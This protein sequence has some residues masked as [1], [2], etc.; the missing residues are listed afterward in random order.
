MLVADSLRCLASGFAF[1]EGPVWLPC[2]SPLLPLTGFEQGCLL[3]SDIER[4]RLYVWCDGEFVVF[5]EN[6]LA[7]NGN[8]LDARGDLLTCE[9]DS[10]RVTRT[11]PDGNIAV[12][13]EYYQGK[14]LNSPN[15]VVARGDGSIF[16]T[17]PPYGVTEEE[18][19]LD[20]QGVFRID[21][22]RQQLDLVVDDFEKPNGLAFAPD[23]ELLYVADTERCHVRALTMTRDGKVTG[24]EV[25]CRAERPDGLRVDQDGNLFVAAMQ[26]IEV[27]DPDGTRSARLDMPVRPANMSFGGADNRWLYI[28]ARTSLFR[29]ETDTVQ[30]SSSDF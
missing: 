1:L 22:Q 12:V 20:Y 11:G 9:H 19:E 3:F 17:D 10:R 27:F 13:A 28:C 6:S 8:A 29:V 14:R 24:D 2:D 4:R 5:R 26:G 7:A 15:D 21:P 23:G 18:R 30:D 25:F 16:F